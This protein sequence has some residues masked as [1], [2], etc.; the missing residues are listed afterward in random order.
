MRYRAILY[1]IDGT[2]LDTY[3]MNTASLSAVLV[4]AGYA[5][6]SLDD[7]KRYYTMPG[8]DT[9]LELNVDNPEALY[10]RWVERAN[11]YASIPFDAI[12]SLFETAKKLG[13]KQGVVS[14]KMRK[15]YGI[16]VVARGWDRYFEVSILKDDTQ[17]HKPHPEPLLKA[18][19]ALN[20]DPSQV[21][22]VGDAL[23]DYLASRAAGMDFIYAS[24][25]SLSGEGIEKPTQQ[26]A[27]VD[28]ARQWLLSLGDAQD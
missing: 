4:E 26:C 13:L 18:C 20:V 6:P 12:E 17:R 24:W 8:M 25:G 9:L 28:E 14:S 5:A 11:T 15:Q 19:A 21:V 1:D 3:E 22:Y 7:L 16:D 10:A 27:T 23:N 2:L